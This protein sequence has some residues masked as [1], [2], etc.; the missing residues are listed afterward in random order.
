[1][2]RKLGRQSVLEKIKWSSEEPQQAWRPDLVMIYMEFPMVPPI[3]S[4]FFMKYFS[5]FAK[6]CLPEEL[7][8]IRWK[9]TEEYTMIFYDRYNFEI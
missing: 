3:E 7:R 5:S 9:E 8:C 1:M 4:L 6:I 2:D